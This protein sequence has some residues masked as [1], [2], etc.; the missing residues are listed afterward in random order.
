MRTGKATTDALNELRDIKRNMLPQLASRNREPRYNRDWSDALECETGVPV[1]E[2]A[3]I[4]AIG[5][6]GSI[7][8]HQ[9]RDLPGSKASLT[10]GIVRREGAALAWRSQPVAFPLFAPPAA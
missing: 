3:L 10:H 6:T 7:G 2:A 1:L 5:R 9:R 4:S 8:A